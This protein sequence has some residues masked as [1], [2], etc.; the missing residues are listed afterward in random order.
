MFLNYLQQLCFSIAGGCQQG[1]T[2][3]QQSYNFL[4][5][6]R[7]I[8]KTG[9]YLGFNWGL[10]MRSKIVLKKCL[11]RV[12]KWTPKVGKNRQERVLE[13][14]QKRISKNSPF[15]EQENEIQLHFSNVGDVK[16]DNFLGTILGPCGR[17]NR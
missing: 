15:Q 3:L 2:F 4:R 1:Q 12:P 8:A 16:K 7:S 10:K 17:Q 5:A 6:S 13:G 9:L 11:Q 14:S